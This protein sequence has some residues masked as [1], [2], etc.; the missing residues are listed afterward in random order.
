[1]VIGHLKLSFVLVL[2]GY[3]IGLLTFLLEMSILILM[4]RRKSLDLLASGRKLM[5][6]TMD[7]GEFREMVA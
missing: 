5:E 3:G 7:D 1:M 6:L 4:K 2:V